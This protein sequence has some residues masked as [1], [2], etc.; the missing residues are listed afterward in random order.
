MS[1]KKTNSLHPRNKAPTS[2]YGGKTLML[3]HI[4]KNIPD[5]KVYIEPF[6]GGGAVY[7]AKELSQGSVINDSNNMVVNFFKTCV[8]DFDNLKQKIEETLFSRAVYTVAMSVWKAPH[9][10]DHVQQA[11]AFFV[12]CNQGWASQVDSWGYD[13]Y[14]K[15]VVSFINKKMRF[16]PEMV[17]RLKTA[18]IESNDALKIIRTYDTKDAFFYLDPPYIGTA[19]GHYKGYTEKDFSEL[20]FALGKIKGKFLL[21][22]FPSGILEKHVKLNG[23]YSVRVEKQNN[24]KKV[25]EGK[26]RTQKKVEV[27]T[28]NYSISL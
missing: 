23:W 16:N 21:S 24:A 10:F 1:N 2:Y 25:D 4:L 19:C 28:A 17:E 26:K 11:W 9:L 15:R 14:G 22:S 12:G 13:K 27:L 7:F 6:F 8:S 20:L 5:H 18:T 3:R